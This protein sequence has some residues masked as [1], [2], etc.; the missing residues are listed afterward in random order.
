MTVW[1]KIVYIKCKYNIG[2]QKYVNTEIIVHTNMTQKYIYIY[3][4]GAAVIDGG[5]DN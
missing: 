1:E 5:G 4:K 3:R 2:I